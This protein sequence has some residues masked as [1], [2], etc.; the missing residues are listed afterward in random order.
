[1][2]HP[3]KT[4]DFSELPECYNFV[5]PSLFLK[6]IKFLVKISSYDREIRLINVLFRGCSQYGKHRDCRNRKLYYPST[7][8]FFQGRMLCNDV[9]YVEIL[10]MAED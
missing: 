5:P 2:T 1:M 3:L 9:S 10:F 6:V 4:L 8:C 7:I